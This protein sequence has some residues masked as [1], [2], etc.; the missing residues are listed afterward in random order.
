RAPAPSAF[1]TPG[2][3]VARLGYPRVGVV[4]PSAGRQPLGS[5]HAPA[6]PW[7]ASLPACWG[8]ATK[9]RAPAPSALG[10][11]GEAVARLGYPRVG[12]VLPSAERQHP[13]RFGTPGEA[14]ARLGYPRVGVVLPSAERQHPRRFGTPGEAVARLGY[15]RVG[16]V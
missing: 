6:K 16:V 11:P 12:V 14:V 3:A 9:R 2:E 15:P 13:R 7:R 4:L 1:G 8:D 10:T 5:R